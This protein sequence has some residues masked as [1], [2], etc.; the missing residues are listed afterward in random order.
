MITPEQANLL[1]AEGLLS[2]RRRPMGWEPK[3]ASLLEFMLMAKKLLEMGIDN[4]GEPWRCT[5]E[6]YRHL[7][8][9]AG[10]IQWALQHHGSGHYATHMLRRS[11][12]PL[13][14][15]RKSELLEDEFLRK[16]CAEKFQ[17]VFD[18]ASNAQPIDVDAWAELKATL[19]R[20]GVQF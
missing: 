10:V 5:S 7:M 20:L 18:A 9:A 2:F 3:L 19:E 15:D 14:A 11:L 8:E 17:K 6:R 16:E 12:H 13:Q 1:V 4:S